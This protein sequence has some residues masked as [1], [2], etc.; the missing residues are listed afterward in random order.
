MTLTIQKQQTALSILG[1][2][3]TIRG[4][5]LQI[6]LDGADAP[7]EKQLKDVLKE[8]ETLIAQAEELKT[9]ALQKLAALGLTVE[10]LTALGVS[11]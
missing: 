10:D 6:H 9:S 11:V 1:I 2:G 3:S 4:E 7:T 8:Q 5:E